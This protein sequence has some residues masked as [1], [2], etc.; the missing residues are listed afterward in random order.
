[1]VTIRDT[2]AVVVRQKH[3]A[4]AILIER[5]EAGEQPPQVVGQLAARQRIG[6]LARHLQRRRLV[7]DRQFRFPAHEVDGAVARDRDHPGHW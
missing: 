1:M 4:A 7:L 3:D 5:A 6:I 2:P